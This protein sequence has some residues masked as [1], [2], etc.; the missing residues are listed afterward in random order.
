MFMPLHLLKK[1][2][3]TSEMNKETLEY[4]QELASLYF[5]SNKPKLANRI[6]EDKFKQ[7]IIDWIFSFDLETRQKICSLD[8]NF[9]AK[10]AQYLFKVY[11]ENHKVNL[12]ICQGGNSVNED[13]VSVNAKLFMQKYLFSLDKSSIQ[14]MEL[15]RKDN[16]EDEIEK[17]LQIEPNSEKLYDCSDNELSMILFF[18]VVN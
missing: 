10:L 5:K 1:D 17:V 4:H 15:S 13:K 16:M 3:K 11:I 8:N 2:S 12:F 6:E 14:T 9:T 7:N 18:E